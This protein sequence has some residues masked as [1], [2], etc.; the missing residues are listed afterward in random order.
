MMASTVSQNKGLSIV[1]C[2]DSAVSTP[3]FI[4]SILL[5]S[6]TTCS[7]NTGTQEGYWTKASRPIYP[8]LDCRCGA[9]STSF[10]VVEPWSRTETPGMPNVYQDDS[11][12]TVYL[13][14]WQHHL[15]A[16]SIV[17]LLS[18]WMSTF[19]NSDVTVV[20]TTSRCDLWYSDRCTV[21]GMELLLGRNPK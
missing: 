4:Y 18:Q 9:E 10:T 8:D 13:V 1:C 15:A 2:W 7:C 16:Y 3:E 12:M 5:G 19:C 21:V 20:G 17:R 14:R 6:G 11:R